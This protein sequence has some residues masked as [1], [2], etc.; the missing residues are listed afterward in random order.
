MQYHPF[1]DDRAAAIELAQQYVSQEPLF[2][3]T[4]TTGLTDRD[5][6]CEIA[7]LDLAGQVLINSLV[8]P[9]RKR[10]W[11]AAAEIHGISR[12][13]VENEPT[14]RELLPELDRILVG[15]TVLVYNAEFDTNKLWST[16]QAN[17]LDENDLHPWWVPTQ[18]GPD[19]QPLNY[20][21]L[22]R[23]AMNLYAMYNGEWN[24]HHQSY[25]WIRLST[26]ARQCGI[27]LPAGIHRA[28]ADA[29]L[30]RLLVLHMAS[31]SKK[32]QLSFLEG[33][34]L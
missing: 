34:G 24:E 16:A 14:F 31:Q 12:E 27:Q 1:P 5:E 2:L 15:R 23:C 30:T 9:A 13:M 17:G 28:H 20:K 4:E 21:S 25:T 19:A 29:E 18:N 7:V 26:A 33:E 6:I 10:E 32:F 3:D 8:K 11:A 22:W